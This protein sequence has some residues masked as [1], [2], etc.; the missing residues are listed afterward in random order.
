[1]TENN[2]GGVRGNV[3]INQAGGNISQTGIELTNKEKALEATMQV[4]FIDR[5]EHWDEYIEKRMTKDETDRKNFAFVI[6]GLWD[7][8]P[9]SFKYRVSRHLK[10]HPPVRPIEL[11]FA[12][13]NVNELIISFEK[14]LLLQLGI[15]RKNNEE[16]KELRTLLSIEL[17]ECL[18]PKLFYF[19]LQDKFVKKPEYIQ[20]IVEYWESL[21]LINSKNQHVLL[22][23][24][25]LEEKGGF[26]SLTERKVEKWRKTLQEKL[27][28]NQHPNVVVPKLESPTR[29]HVIEWIGKELEDNLHR[30]MF[31]EDFAAIKDKYIPHLTLKHTF[32]KIA[33]SKI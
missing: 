2:F 3:I 6:A 24:Y 18:E 17:L 28:K 14:D 25:D 7:E 29:K 23:I 21:E 4:A 26:F 15:P 12:A 22:I 8:W 27:S 19:T 5:F 9:E 13:H 16:P 33:R 10:I 32:T 30:T 31:E 20:A 11:D 1:M